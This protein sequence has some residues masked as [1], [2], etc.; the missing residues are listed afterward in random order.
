MTNQSTSNNAQCST[1]L[2]YAQTRKRIHHNT[3]DVGKYAHTKHHIFITTYI[4][5]H[6]PLGF[7]T[8]FYYVDASNNKDPQIR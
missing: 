5:G 3:I 8:W 7:T 6:F 2:T 1:Y 4:Y